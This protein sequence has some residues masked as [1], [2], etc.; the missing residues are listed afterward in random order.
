MLGCETLS[1]S[2][3]TT[4]NTTNAI[5]IMSGGTPP[6]TVTNFFTG[7]YIEVTGIFTGHAVCNNGIWLGLGGE[8]SYDEDGIPETCEI[9][10][11]TL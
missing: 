2:V 3:D 9:R 11:N 7:L 4:Y 10:K 8:I 5:T 1:E 6:S